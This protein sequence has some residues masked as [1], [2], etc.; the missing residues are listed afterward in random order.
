MPTRGSVGLGERPRR[1]DAP[2]DSRCRCS[3]RLPSC[4]WVAPPFHRAVAVADLFL[5]R[6]VHAKGMGR[7]RSPC[8]GGGICALPTVMV[9][10]RDNNGSSSFLNRRNSSSISDGKELEES[11]GVG[12]LPW[13]ALLDPPPLHRATILLSNPML[14][15]TGDLA[16]EVCLAFS[17]VVPLGIGPV[18]QTDAAAVALAVSALWWAPQMAVRGCVDHASK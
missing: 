7:E 11:V 6:S 10:W 3:Y 9:R 8:L 15:T 13:N 18:V 17:V 5:L 14:S 12:F 4:Q 16:V 1:D 2:Y